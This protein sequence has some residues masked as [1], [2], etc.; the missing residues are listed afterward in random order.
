MSS[1]NL[2]TRLAPRSRSRSSSPPS[3]Q[4]ADRSRSPSPP[5]APPAPP[6][7]D[8]T[9]IARISRRK[10]VAAANESATRDSLELRRVVLIQGAMHAATSAANS[11]SPSP[12]RALVNAQPPPQIVVSPPLQHPA[13]GLEE[14]Q[15]E[16]RWF[17]AVLEELDLDWDDEDE[18]TA[19]VTVQTVHESDVTS[20]GAISESGSDGVPSLEEFFYPPPPPYSYAP[21]PANTQQGPFMDAAY[22]PPL[23]DSFA[24]DAWDDYDDG[25]EKLNLVTLFSDVDLGAAVSATSGASMKAEHANYA[26]APIVPIG[27]PPSYGMYP[28]ISPYEFAWPSSRYDAVVY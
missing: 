3:T 1:L 8:P 24:A 26:P 11:R 15:A 12:P 22:P 13:F 16:E 25:S 6:I 2:L 28:P 7:M 27:L 21:A 19:M 14:L 9:T 18:V 20:D 5:K 10:L 17:D 4:G 23:P